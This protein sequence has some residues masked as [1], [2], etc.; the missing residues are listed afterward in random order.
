MAS[1]LFRLTGQAFNLTGQ[2]SPRLAGRLAY[3][4]FSSTGNRKPKSEKERAFLA[5]SASRMAEGTQT[6]LQIMGGQSVTS[7]SF[8]PIGEANGRKVLVVH[9]WGSRIDFLEPLVTTLRRQGFAVVGLDLPG[10]G[11][12]TGRLLTVP[13]ALDGIDKAWAEH[14]P[15]D[16][17]VGHSFG[18]F[19]TALSVSGAGGMVKPRTPKKLVII[20]AP[21]DARNVFRKY[22]SM[23]GFSDGVARA[24][25]S[26]AEQVIGVPAEHFHAPSH[27]KALEDL[28]VL[29]L[30]AEDD[31]EV[32]SQSAREYAAAGPQVTLSWMN[33]KGHRRIVSSPETMEAI[34]NFIV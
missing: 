23:L 33:G 10:H 25:L 24:M 1:Y 2:F 19:A 6:R 3:R 22:Q 4:V 12:S 20:A 15:F 31:K 13:M 21:A 26:H 18:G 30:H 28:P 17:V 29:V 7:H 27:L 32:D 9:G 14:G 5:A 34:T 8:E 11:A 16:F